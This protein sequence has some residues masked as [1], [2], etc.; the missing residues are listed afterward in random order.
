MPPVKTP[1][2]LLPGEEAKPPSVEH[3]TCRGASNLG[4]CEL[5]RAGGDYLAVTRQDSECLRKP[6]SDLS[7]SV[8][9]EVWVRVERDSHWQDSAEK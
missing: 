6:P 2:A 5:N 3:V 8:G 7:G 4:G 1:E 9:G